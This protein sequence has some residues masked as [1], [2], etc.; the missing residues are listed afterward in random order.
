VPIAI[1]GQRFVVEDEVPPLCRV[2]LNLLRAYH[3]GQD[4]IEPPADPII[5]VTTS[6]DDGAW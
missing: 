1:L 2:V 4:H 5:G 3:Q 6:D